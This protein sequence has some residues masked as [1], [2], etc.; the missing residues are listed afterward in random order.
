MARYG[1]LFSGS[2]GNCTYVGTAAGGILVDVGVSAKRIKAALCD[3]EI[4]P[5]RIFGILI[6]HEHSD[7]IAGLRVLTKQY[8][9]PVYAAP[10][11]LTALLSM[12]AVDVASDLIPLDETAVCVGDMQVTPFHTPHDAAESMGFCIETPDER[13]IAVATD[14]GEMRP[15]V[16]ERLSNCDL[17]HME[18][19]HDVTMLQNGPYPYPLK[20]RI[21]SV[22]GHLSNTACAQAA[23]ELAAT[24]VARFTLAHLSEQNNTPALALQTTGAAL[25][26]AG[27]TMGADYLLQVAAPISTSPLTVF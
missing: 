20:K 5:E 19:N 13:R 18:S 22:S 15:S 25:C 4:S 17:V 3:R 24:G 7:H 1:A 2:K 11:T 9:I 14:M 23:C 6:T 16:L 27:F 21:L 8:G 10:G 26:Q 12:K